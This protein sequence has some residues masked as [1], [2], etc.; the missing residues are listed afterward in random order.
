MYKVMVRTKFLIGS[1]LVAGLVMLGGCYDFSQFDNIKVEPT[2]PQ[3]VVP[4]VN[5][6]ISFS[7][8]VEGEDANT[9][10]FTK[11][12][13][14]RFFIAFRDTLD[15]F[16]A[17]TR[18]SFPD[19]NFS[20]VYQLDASEVPGG[21]L[22]SG[23]SL[24]PITKELSETYNSIAGAEVKTVKLTAG[25]LNI[26]VV[27]HFQND[28]KAEIKFP[29]VLDAQGDTL[30][31]I[32]DRTLPSQT[33]T[34]QISSLANYTLNLTDGTLYN[35][36]R[37]E[38]KLTIHSLGNPIT[39]TDYADIQL[40]LSGLD[41]EYIVG[42]LNE[43]FPLNDIKLNLD[44][45]SSAF[46][47]DFSLAEPKLTMKFENAFGIPL[48]FDINTFK[49]TNSNTGQQVNLVN[50]G[51]PPAGSLL[52]TQTNGIDYQA[53]LTQQ[54]PQYDSMYV[55][56]QNS[57]L[58][59]FLAIAPDSILVQSSLVVGDASDNHNY[60]VKKS[61]TLKMINEIEFP[62]VGWIEN[63]VIRDTVEVDLPNLEEDLNLVND[64]SLKI[65]LKLK[66]INSIP[67]N[68]YFQG[69]F[70][71]DADTLLTQLYDDASELLLVKSSQINPTTGKTSAPTTHYAYI[72]I[73][74]SKYD[75]ME[76][77]TKMVLEV[78]MQTGGS[79]QQNVVVESTNTLQ[80][81]LSVELEGTVDLNDL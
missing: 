58:E 67:L 12:G 45:F 20:K 17:A 48:G 76:I 1:L 43:T 4:A 65:R 11:P 80:A 54:Q 64:N 56:H 35:T 77:A 73:D 70:Y 60:F 46:E 66:L 23:D 74:K 79:T 18:Y 3:M 24:G 59:D 7:D 9:I 41:F 22:P 40:S 71:D 26:S 68:V 57:N 49:S 30:V 27:N 2:S 63:L 78:R 21:I 42:K 44:A 51:V 53:S 37:V 69:L 81:M 29:S 55:D 34:N 16:D 14:T 50:E 32:M 47:A 10:I 33:Y 61:S 75:M 15:L 25:S 13:D 39:T 36:F 31:F 19:F 28:I 52:V 38:V 8:V 72:D 6:T 5:S 62:L